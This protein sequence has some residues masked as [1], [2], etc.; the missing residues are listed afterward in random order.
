L[1]QLESK[2]RAWAKVADGVYVVTGAVFDKDDNGQRDADADADLVSPTNRVAI[3]TAFYKIILHVR[4]SGFI[5]T[6]SILLPHL[7]ES[8]GA[9]NR[10]SLIILLPLMRLKR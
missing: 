3:P 9:T 7:D 6:I 8:V 1:G 2:V 5:D 4:P 10:T